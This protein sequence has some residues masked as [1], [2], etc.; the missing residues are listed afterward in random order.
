MGVGRGLSVQAG[1]SRRRE[2]LRRRCFSGVSLL[3]IWFRHGFAAQAQQLLVPESLLQPDR[4]R[5]RSR[6]QSDQTI[7]EGWLQRLTAAVEQ[8]HLHQGATVAAASLEPE[9]ILMVHQEAVSIQADPHP[10]AC[11]TIPQVLQWCVPELPVEQQRLTIDV[12]HHRIGDQPGFVLRRLRAFK[13]LPLV[14]SP[15]Q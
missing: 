14:Q 8:L 7:V 4:P 5:V 12:S 13:A 3:F 9:S 1:S 2:R 10:P 6:L 15:L 11:I